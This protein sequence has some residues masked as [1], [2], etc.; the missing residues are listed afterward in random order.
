M[1]LSQKLLGLA[2]VALADYACCP[3]DDYGLPDS[4]CTTALR[5]KTPFA[6]S[7]QQP[8]IQNDCK[9][10]EFN[11]DAIFEGND[12]C[13][14][15]YGQCGFQRQFSWDAEGAASGTAASTL[16]HYPGISADFK[17]EFGIDT[18]ANTKDF[19][20]EYGTSTFTYS[21]T[22]LGERQASDGWGIGRAP[23][24]GGICKLFVPVPPKYIVQVQVAGVH[25]DG[26]SHTMF[27]GRFKASASESFVDGTVFC[28]SVVNPSEG[29]VN[30][31]GVAN[32]NVNGQG[33]IGALAFGDDFAT[34]NSL[35]RQAGL[36]PAVSF[37]SALVGTP[38]NSIDGA[39]DGNNSRGAN[40]DVVAHFD[41]TWCT[42]NNSLATVVEMQQAGDYRD[43]DDSYDITS[44]HAHNDIYEKRHA[45][46][47]YGSI[48][49]LSG[50]YMVAGG[51]NYRWPNRGA[52]AGYHSVVTC[53]QYSTA[54][55]ALVYNTGREYVMSVSAGD[56]R[57]GAN[58]SCT[59]LNY[60]FNVRQVGTDVVNCGPGQLPDADDKRCTWNWNYD[61]DANG[62]TEEFFDRTNN[63][64]FN[65]W[66]SG[67]KRRQAAVTHDLA[68]P[69]VSNG[70]STSNKVFTFTFVDGLGSAP[71]NVVLS[72][73]ND[74]TP[75]Y[76]DIGSNVA[77][78]KCATTG[79]AP[80]RDNF[81]DCFFGDELHFSVSYEASSTNQAEL[82]RARINSWYSKVSVA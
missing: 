47:D 5:E 82:P 78:L 66:N 51:V 81:P 62:E 2:G 67:R 59:G 36:A 12:K 41:T 45:R 9:A 39:N 23:I 33:A 13:G 74:G 76:V 22:A 20:T 37:G 17:L 4:T 42:N 1:K 73:D 43:G 26:A 15:N 49:T 24:L 61:A 34:L 54:T 75:D 56:F 31:N 48:Y 32:G 11:A 72:S 70:P 38:G 79:V 80:F 52:W 21:G 30:D 16:T 71:K 27:P 29:D 68:D 28:F 58:T 44:D 14:V 77:T 10:W 55:D 46:V 69:N 63:L 25:K 19:D 50:G 6:E 60:R 57:Q 64:V 18:I 65:T 8:W 53:A 3:Y 7:A 35:Q 40:F